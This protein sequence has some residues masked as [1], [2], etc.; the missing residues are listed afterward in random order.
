MGYMYQVL[1]F[2]SKQTAVTFEEP[3]V[4]PRWIST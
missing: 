1:R 4:I 3:M 2:L